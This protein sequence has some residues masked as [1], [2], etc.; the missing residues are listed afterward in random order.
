MLLSLYLVRGEALP[1]VAVLREAEA[2]GEDVWLSPAG[3][4][5][6]LRTCSLTPREI[7][8][9]D[10][11]LL[12]LLHDHWPRDLWVSWSTHTD[13]IGI[14]TLDSPGR[15][16]E[17]ERALHS[18]CPSRTTLELFS[19]VSPLHVIPVAVQSLSHV[20]LFFDPMDCSPPDSSV[21]GLSQ[22]RILEWATISFSRGFSQ[23]KDRIHIS[24]TGRRILHRWAPGKPQVPY[25]QT[26]NLGT[27]KDG[28]MPSCFAVV[29]KVLYCQI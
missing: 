1:D 25:I 23:P 24:C 3:Q 11:G 4:R 21:H 13:V 16:L 29:F 2:G 18:L 7:W 5:L 19:A 14:I 27:F 26:F 22:A 10:G 12:G 6:R 8:G 20:R 9:W 17:W 15:E 28:N